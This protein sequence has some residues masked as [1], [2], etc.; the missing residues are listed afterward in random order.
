[1]DALKAPGG[2]MTASLLGLLALTLVSVALAFFLKES[3]IHEQK[4]MKVE[5]AGK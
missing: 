5:G 4:S 2:S 3:P 1:M